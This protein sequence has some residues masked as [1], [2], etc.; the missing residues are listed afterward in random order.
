MM[1]SK[2]N[3]GS[4]LVN[5]RDLYSNS[6]AFSSAISLDMLSTEAWQLGEGEIP[7]TRRG[8]KISAG[9]REVWRGGDSRNA[10]WHG[11]GVSSTS[12]WWLSVAQV[13]GPTFKWLKIMGYHGLH[14]WDT[15]PPSSDLCFGYPELLLAVQTW[16]KRGFRGHDAVV[17]WFTFSVQFCPWIFLNP[18]TFHWKQTQ[19]KIPYV[20]QDSVDGKKKSGGVL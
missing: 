11:V 20:W 19:R 17:Q 4:I 15:F 16:T 2:R 18:K 1:V 7:P 8:P 9:Q 5:I 6:T 3:S 13:M 14:L 12:T 10:G